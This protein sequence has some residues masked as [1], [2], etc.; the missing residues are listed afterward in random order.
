MRRKIRKRANKTMRMMMNNKETRNS[1]K[2]NRRIDRKKSRMDRKK[3]NSMR[4]KINSWM[5]RMPILKR[6]K[7]KTIKK[8]S[9][10][11]MIKRWTNSK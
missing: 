3:K 7:E 8:D 5:R 4:V 11:M 10:K 6:W 9:S 2:K 1:N